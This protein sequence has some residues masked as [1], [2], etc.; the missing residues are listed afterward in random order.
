VKRLLI[1]A[2]VALGIAVATPAVLAA[3]PMA[4]TGRVLISTQGD[5]S[6]PA[7]D[8]ADF[9]LVVQGNADI[10]GEV[11]TIVVI[12]GTANLVGARSESVVAIRSELEVGPGTVVSQEV[13]RLDS[14]VHQTGDAE[15]TGGIKDLAA[16]FVEVGAVLAPAMFLLWIGFGLATIVAALVV[17]GIAGR[18]LR[19]AERLLAAQ[20]LQTLLV[21]L[22][23]VIGLPIVAIFLIATIIGAPLGIGILIGTLPLVAFIGYL[24]AATWIGE[25]IVRNTVSGTPPERPFLAAVAGVLVLEAIGLIPILTIVVAIASLLGF[26]AVIRLAFRAL[27]GTSVPYADAPRAVAA[28]TGA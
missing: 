2:A 23:S 12:D 4:H 14:T 15:I 16:S 22:V 6:V 28:A 13:L 20:P 8:Q 11:N 1:V 5:V 3:E 9:V 27:R 21:G 19:K 7:G 10:R 24:V 18:Q 26:G 25:W 17:A